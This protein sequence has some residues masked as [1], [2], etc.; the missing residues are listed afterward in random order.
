MER[1][2]YLD[3]YP[4]YSVSD[5]GRF[6]N[7]ETGRILAVVCNQ[8]GLVFVG[9]TVNGRQYKRGVAKLVA[10]KWLPHNTLET[11]DT[12]LHR[13]GDRFNNAV[14]N[15]VW[16]PRFYA[17][18]YLRQ[19]E[20]RGYR[21]PYIDHPLQEIETGLVFNNSWEAMQHFGVLEYNVA[22]AYYEDVTAWPTT[23]KFEDPV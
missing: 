20:G 3:E 9:L 22:R 2:L 17:N 7:E 11:F 1:W 14:S 5:L 16:R 12:P 19:F 15:L 6:R 13:D 21:R 18:K 23:A 8:G 10:D 4:G